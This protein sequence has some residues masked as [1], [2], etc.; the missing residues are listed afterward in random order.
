MCLRVSGAC[1]G[2]SCMCVHNAY[3]R[4]PLSHALLICLTAESTRVP[5]RTH[6]VRL[7]GNGGTVHV[8]STPPHPHNAV[9]PLIG[10]GALQPLSIYKSEAQDMGVVEGGQR[11]ARSKSKEWLNFGNEWPKVVHV[12]GPTRASDDAERDKSGVNVCV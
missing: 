12:E 7:V 6:T 2:V 11:E 9:A 1:V 4:T 5:T 10:M 3:P 8:Q